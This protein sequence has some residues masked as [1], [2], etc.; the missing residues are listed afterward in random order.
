MA[1]SLLDMRTRF[2]LLIASGTIFSVKYGI[3]LSMQSCKDSLFG[4][5]RAFTNRPCSM[6]RMSDSREETRTSLRNLL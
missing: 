5:L 6:D 1:F 3:V 4:N 2:P